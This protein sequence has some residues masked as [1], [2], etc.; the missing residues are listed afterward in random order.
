MNH[1]RFKFSLSAHGMPYDVET[2]GTL[3]EALIHVLQKT[4]L[5]LIDLRDVQKVATKEPEPRS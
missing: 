5:S 2:D 1:W 4:G 3:G